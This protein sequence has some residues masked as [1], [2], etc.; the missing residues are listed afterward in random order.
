MAAGKYPPYRPSSAD[1]A[2]FSQLKQLTEK[3]AALE[4][5]INEQQRL[6]N[7]QAQEPRTI[8][9]IPGKRFTHIV[10]LSLT[11][12]AGATDRVVATYNVGA[13]GPWVLT[14]ASMSYRKTEGSY[15]GIDGPVTMLGQAISPQHLELGYNNIYNTPVGQ[16]ITWEL[17]DASSG[18]QF[19]NSPISG[20]I[21]NVYNGA[22]FYLPVEHV[23]PPASVVEVAVTPR[24]AQTNAGIVDVTLLGYR[25]LQNPEYQP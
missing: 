8:A 7:Q 6:L 14:G 20:A 12:E 17:R 2:A 22:V 4:A 3:L 25:I 18:R 24:V 9:D 21:F 1:R 11:I 5:I 10:A 16:S 13:D 23:F 19:Q 15:L